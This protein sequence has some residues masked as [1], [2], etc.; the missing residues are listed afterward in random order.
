MGTRWEF[1]GDYQVVKVGYVE[2]S[3]A[4]EDAGSEG[5]HPR[6]LRGF[7]DASQLVL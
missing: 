7:Q 4:D 2:A 5:Q 6:D 1:G 3:K